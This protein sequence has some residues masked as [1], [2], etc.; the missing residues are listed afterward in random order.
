ID[1]LTYFCRRLD[2]QQGIQTIA[3][4][5]YWSGKQWL[6]RRYPVI[7]ERIKFEREQHSWS[8]SE[9]A[10]QSGVNQAYISQLERGIRKRASAEILQRIARA[11]GLTVDAL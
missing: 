1:I 9:L 10:R 8:Q 6:R 2:V 4:V 3:V 5:I 11:F 7:G